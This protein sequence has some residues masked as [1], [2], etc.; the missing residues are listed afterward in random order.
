MSRNSSPKPEAEKIASQNVDQPSADTNSESLLE[1][2]FI[3]QLKDILA[4][5]RQLK[6]V[7]PR[8]QAAATT[9][10][11]KEAFDDHLYVTG[12][13][14][15]RAEKLLSWFNRDASAEKCKAMEGLVKEADEIIAFTQPGTMTRDAALIIATQKIEHYEMATYGGLVQL[16]IT[17]KLYDAAELLERT[18]MEEEEADK[19]LTDVAESY[20]NIEA[21]EETKYSW[22]KKQ[23]QEE[24]G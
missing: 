15:A 6:E 20:I 7:L 14:A 8:L 1:L 9:A 22:L 17:M 12:K 3:E 23:N 16:A 19:K 5:E 11:L 18:L 21:E 10:E 4:A 24:E 2:F 13:H